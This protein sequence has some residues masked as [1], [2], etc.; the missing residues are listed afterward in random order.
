MKSLVEKGLHFDEERDD[1][2][3][4]VKKFED[5]H[6]T[7]NIIRDYDGFDC[8]EHEYLHISKKEYDN[9]RLDSQVF[10]PDRRLSNE[11]VRRLLD[12]NSLVEIA[13]KTQEER[14]R[15][16]GNDSHVGRT[17]TEREEA[18]KESDDGNEV[19][20]ATAAKLDNPPDMSMRETILPGSG[21]EEKSPH[22]YPLTA[23]KASETSTKSRPKMPQGLRSS[24]V[25]DFSQQ[26]AAH[27]NDQEPGAEENPI[28][29]E[30]RSPI[31][32]A[33]AFPNL[34]G[35]TDEASACRIS[36]VKRSIA[37]QL[38]RQSNLVRR[39]TSPIADADNSFEELS[40]V[41]SATVPVF[42]LQGSQDTI[43]IDSLREAKDRD[44]QA[45][46]VSDTTV[47]PTETRPA[48]EQE[49]PEDEVQE[50]AEVVFNV[51]IVHTDNFGRLVMHALTVAEAISPG[52]GAVFV[53]RRVE[54]E[55][56]EDYSLRLVIARGGEEQRSE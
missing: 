20:N 17:L 49:A 14:N 38:S 11:W 30:L 56:W 32:A 4:F 7:T 25:Q 29:E 3:A 26:P 44:T 19:A 46:T 9:V 54:L 1:C 8:A 50:T 18:G 43:D 55:D 53:A 48:Q 2:A 28:L 34:K 13:S 40:P 37:E 35:A 42:K 6:R 16:A 47:V 15:V 51:S 33:A 23:N 39:I 31:D 10:Q 5:Y 45:P 27:S 12:S 36:N 22:K 21:A 24:F 41:R 52:F